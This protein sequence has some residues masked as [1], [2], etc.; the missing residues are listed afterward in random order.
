MA[1]FVVCESTIFT[2]A[3]ETATSFASTNFCLRMILRHLPNALTL[4]NLLC[5]CAGLVAV[6]EG[7]LALA[8]YLIWAAAAFDFADGLAARALNAYSPIGADLDSLADM[9]SF[10]AL[11]G[12]IMF[13]LIEGGADSEWSLVAYLGFS[14]AVFSALRLAIFN[15]DTRQKDQFIGLPVP[16]SA[17]LVSAL[18]L[19]DLP[20]FRS[21]VQEPLV[22][23]SVVAVLSYLMVAPVPLLAF[24]F[25][26]KAWQGNQVKYVFLVVAALLFVLLKVVAIP[27]II[28]AYVLLSV[29]LN[30][31]QRSNAG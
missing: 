15:V 31:R 19:G 1:L 18:P 24:K 20:I 21:L 27:I 25:K 5:G 26:S 28:I 2:A 16:A 9:V 7:N 10:G 22:L 30:S 12:F 4:S 29:V 17:L 13:R 11:P 23:L 3:R 8:A 14:L 6:A